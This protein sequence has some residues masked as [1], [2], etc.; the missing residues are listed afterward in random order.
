VAYIEVSIASSVVPLGEDVT[1]ISVRSVLEGFPGRRLTR[2][3]P[4]DRRGS[5]ELRIA[6]S[7]VLSP[8]CTWRQCM[9]SIRPEEVVVAAVRERCAAPVHGVAR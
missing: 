3:V 7:G 8:D 5:R 6:P 9:R 1:S 2:L 4:V